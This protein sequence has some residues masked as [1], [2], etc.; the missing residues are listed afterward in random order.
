V[1]AS[2][3]TGIL[4]PDADD[5]E[6]VSS[7]SSMPR[8][9]GSG[10]EARGLNVPCVHT[11]PCAL[12]LD[13]RSWLWSPE[14]KG[15][16]SEA[17]TPPR[18]DEATGSALVDGRVGVRGRSSSWSWP[19]PLSLPLGGGCVWRRLLGCAGRWSAEEEPTRLLDGLPVM[20]AAWPSDSDSTGSVD[21]Q[22]I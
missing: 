7:S 8:I 1:M 22:G 14:I 15:V 12:E 20:V 18:G 3:I 9:K 17:K 19:L 11:P 10:L 5:I 16:D 21:D 4:V 2:S 13:R 6:A